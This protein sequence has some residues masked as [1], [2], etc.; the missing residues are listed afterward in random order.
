M[1]EY[2]SPASTANPFATGD[3]GVVVDALTASGL[4]PAEIDAAVDLFTRTI[5]SPLVTFSLRLRRAGNEVLFEGA[6]GPGLALFAEPAYAGGAGQLTL[7]LPDEFPR[8]VAD[9]VELGPRPFDDAWP[10][11]PMPYEPLD[12]FA[13]VGCGEEV[14]ASVREAFAGQIDA[15]LLGGLYGG[16]ALRWTLSFAS[17]GHPDGDPLLDVIDA[18]DCGLWLIEEGPEPESVW[19]RPMTSTAAWLLI[20]GQVNAALLAVTS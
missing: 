3:L 13:G 12:A 16:E 15:D 8:V 14:L 7:G 6:L 19:V 17:G 9:L 10:E 2:V 11:L 20:V 4:A 1:L 5:R 18:D